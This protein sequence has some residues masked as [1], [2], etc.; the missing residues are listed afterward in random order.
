VSVHD[1]GREVSS[2]RMAVEPPQSG[3]SAP[4]RLLKIAAF[5]DVHA[6][7]GSPW[8]PTEADLLTLAEADL[9]LIAGDVCDTGVP[10]DAARVARLVVENTAAPCFAVLGNHDHAAG[11]PA[12]VAEALRALGLHV[13][14]PGF[15]IV[16]TAGIR[17]GVAGTKG[18]WGSGWPDYPVGLIGEAEMGAI[19]DA[20]ACEVGRLANELKSIAAVELR[21]ALLHYSPTVTTLRGE[22][23]YV[24]PFMGAD[25]LAVPILTGCADVVIHGHSHFG[26]THG[27]VGP[28]PVYNVALPATGGHISR[29]ELTVGE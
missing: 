17:V 5:G 24:L 12:E 28:V 13:L 10:E 21:V 6:H 9:V 22:D 15:G 1:V 11:R 25:A 3:T 18:F 26:G 27:R 29:I 19:E 20:L 14:D 7:A 8:A 23:E 16:E 2:F 4:P